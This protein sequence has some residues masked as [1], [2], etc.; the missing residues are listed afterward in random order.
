VIAHHKD[1]FGN[2]RL[3]GLNDHEVGKMVRV[4]VSANLQVL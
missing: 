1:A 4:H 2:A 3:T